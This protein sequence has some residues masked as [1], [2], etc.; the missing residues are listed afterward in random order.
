MDAF[1][2]LL[3][4]GHEAKLWASWCQPALRYF[5]FFSSASSHLPR[6]QTAVVWIQSLP[7]HS[8]SWDCPQKP[9]DVSRYTSISH[10]FGEGVVMTFSFPAQ[11]LDFHKEQCHTLPSTSDGQSLPCCSQS[12]FKG[13]VPLPPC[14]TAFPPPSFVIFQ[15]KLIGLKVMVAQRKEFLLYNKFLVFA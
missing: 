10:N 6:R 4:Y 15:S 5:F 13:A 11:L 2:V 9:R 1:V 3:D 7:A 8:C 14:D 12:S